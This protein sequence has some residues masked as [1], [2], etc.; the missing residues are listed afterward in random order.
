MQYTSVMNRQ[1]LSDLMDKVKH[2]PVGLVESAEARYQGEIENVCQAV[3]EHKKK[4]I[5]LCGPSS[6]GKTTSAKKLIDTLRAN[7]HKVN[8]VSLDDFYKNKEE[9]PLWND[10]SINFESIEGLDLSLF[11]SQMQTLFEKG[12]ADFPVFNF[13]KPEVRET[14]RLYYDDD[15]YTIVEGIHALNPK[16]SESLNGLP[17]CRVYVSVHT[18]FVH[19]DGSIKLKGRTLRL[20]RR[21]IRDKTHRNT[22]PETTFQMWDYILKG[23]RLYIQ[24]YR[25]DADFHIDTTH[26][27][28]PFIFARHVQNLLGDNQQEGLAALLRSSFEG[29]PSM[30][31]ALVPRNS[32][33]QEFIGK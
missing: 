28:E 25:K 5:L 29:L 2:D 27:Y 26:A 30:D 14:F 20:A 11:H 17:C 15:T 16:I 33:L 7:G 24:P 4:V 31:E 1:S 21:T 8:R 13:K 32:L 22:D 6:A 10:G 18:D 19:A 3:V 12:E 23:E 9:L